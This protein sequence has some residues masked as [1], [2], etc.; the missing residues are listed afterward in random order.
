M[1]KEFKEINLKHLID[2]QMELNWYSERYED[3]QKIEWWFSK[4]TTTPEKEK[5]FIE[6]TKIYL[7]PFS[8]KIKYILNKQVSWFILNFWLRTI[9]EE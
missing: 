4:F 7:K 8:W 6:Y 3:L 9:W 5:E 1:A 2:Y